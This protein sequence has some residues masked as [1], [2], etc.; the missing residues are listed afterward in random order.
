MAPV[1]QSPDSV[2]R[3]FHACKVSAMTALLTPEQED[4]FAKDARRTVTLLKADA[5]CSSCWHPII[6]AP[7][8]VVKFFGGQIPPNYTGTYAI[9]CGSRLAEVCLPCSIIYGIDANRLVKKGLEGDGEYVPIS[10]S[11]NLRLFFTVTLESFGQVHHVVERKGHAGQC[12]PGKKEFC[13]K[14]GFQISC[15]KI[16]TKDDPEVGSPM[17]PD[18]YQLEDAVLAN[19]TVGELWNRFIDHE[20]LRELAKILKVDRELLAD[21]LHIES[22]K[23]SEMQSRGAIHFHGFIRLDGP[24]PKART[25][26][27]QSKK[28]T[29]LGKNDSVEKIY[30]TQGSH[31]LIK[32]T[33]VQLVKAFERAAKK[34]VIHKKFKLSKNDPTPIE[35]DFR[36]GKQLDVVVVTAKNSKMFAAYVAKYATKS[37][38]DVLGFARTFHSLAQI[39]ALSDAAWWPKL[40]AQ[41]A[42]ELGENPRYK[43]LKLQLHANTFGFRGHFLSK[44]RQWSVSFVRLKQIR[45]QW[46]IDHDDL[47]NSLGLNVPPDAFE[48]ANISWAVLKIGWFT[49]L[50]ALAIETWYEHDK[51]CREFERNRELEVAA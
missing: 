25:N 38:T 36:F 22:V 28:A 11:E 20:L 3:P 13:R 29:K 43:K 24:R 17:C 5:N 44:S 49:S 27:K 37:A 8:D 45:I 7:E 46:A 42:W 32:V 16:H 9:R 21:F 19:A 18:C 41:T 39:K 6:I 30:N 40:L 26:K 33:D 2:D 48:D 31:P 35:K 51:D 12:H 15:N 50:D 10:V 34:T 23:T 1:L 14:H 47:E 4:I